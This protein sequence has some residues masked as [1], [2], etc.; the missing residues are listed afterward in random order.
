M[1][2]SVAYGVWED[3]KGINLQ[4]VTLPPLDFESIQYRAIVTSYSIQIPEIDLAYYMHTILQKIYNTVG[5]K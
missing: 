1:Y 3:K 5:E 4:V 2:S